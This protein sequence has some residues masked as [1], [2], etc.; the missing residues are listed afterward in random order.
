MRARGDKLDGKADHRAV[1]WG[2]SC[3]KSGGDVWTETAEGRDD[4]LCVV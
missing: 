1:K 4:E 2:V 3:W